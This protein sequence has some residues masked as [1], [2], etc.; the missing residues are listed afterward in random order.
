MVR[1]GAGMLLLP[2]ASARQGKWLGGAWLI[3]YTLQFLDKVCIAGL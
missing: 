3:L 2:T 1:V